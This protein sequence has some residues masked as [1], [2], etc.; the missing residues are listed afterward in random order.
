MKKILVPTDFSTY[1]N[2][3]LHVA[4]QLAQRFEATLILMHNIEAVSGAL[5]APSSLSIDNTMLDSELILNFTENTKRKLAE[6]LSEQDLSNVAVE[7]VVEIGKLYPSILEV[8][9][10]MNVDL[11]VMGTK[12]ASGLEEF[13]IGSNTEKVVR[14][15]PCPVLAVKNRPTG[16]QMK[17]IVF[18]T[19]L[20]EDQLYATA[21]LKVFQTLFEAHL[22]I[23]RVNTP[24]SFITSREAE[25]KFTAF[26]HKYQIENYSTHLYAALNEEIGIIEFAA[27]KKADMI[28]LA[29]RSEERRV[30]KECRSR[31]SP[32]H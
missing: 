19:N 15:A 18:A 2:S 14:N 28:A 11:V 6:Q 9:K 31:W 3:A 24:S 16:W 26:A 30:G 4:I 13:V 12:G 10:E 32:Y 25:E 5:I 1:A 23:L 27:L 7:Y 22:H 20:E 17:D 29:T 21:K 8:I